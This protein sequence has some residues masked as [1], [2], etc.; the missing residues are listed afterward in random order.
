MMFPLGRSVGLVA[1]FAGFALSQPYRGCSPPRGP[2]PV[3]TTKCQGKTYTYNELA[4]FGSIPSD[5][6]DKFGD[7]VSVGSSAA[8]TDW[9]KKTDPKTKLTSYT[10]TLYGLPDRGWNTEGTQNTIPRVHLFDITFTPG[11]SSSTGA[12]ASPNLAFSYR[13][14][15]LLSAPNGEPMTG[16]DPD[17][18]TTSE[19]YPGFP[20]MPLATYPGDGFGGSGPGGARIALDAE[21]LLLNADGSFWISDEYGPYLYLFSSSGEM[22]QAVAPPD[23]L[24]PVRAW[25]NETGAT[26]NPSFSSNNPPIFNAKKIPA[27][28]D[29]LAGRTNNQGYEGLSAS[30][31]NAETG[32]REIWVLL[33]SASRLEGG[34]D[35]TTR[36]HVRLLKYAVGKEGK[37]KGKGKGKG[38]Y[39]RNKKG[40]QPLEVELEGEYV[41]PL[42]VFT[43]GKGKTKVA[44]Q[45]E[46]KYIG[47]GQLLVLPRDSSVGA[48]TDS[49]TSIYR[50]VDVIDVNGAT[51]VKEKYDAFNASVA[52]IY[53]VLNP[54]VK[55]ATLCPWLDFNVNEQLSKFGMR[56]GPPALPTKSLLNEKWESLALVPVEEG[57]KDEYFL[58][59]LSDNDF[60]TQNGYM[61][62]G[63]N[64]YKDGSGCNLDHQAL[65]FKVTLPKGSKPLIG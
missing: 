13:D 43:D 47:D 40:E 63:K 8:I 46:I 45:S 28:G 44:A 53:G 52:G 14:T 64:S 59:S 19:L 48:C 12:A 37:G 42:P 61:N 2:P 34:Q 32:E 22:L 55:P 36:R 58:F 6:R 35:A 33:Q 9:K 20:K 23:A 51:D 24:L 50:H 1:F 30:P 41:V 25:A 38:N 65:V 60:I 5:A 7:T 16:L 4:G 39:K 18:Y 26:P 3:S 29:P 11:S 49:P 21:G 17:T 15:I 31:E 27:P 54:D 62:G 57:N 10:G 56:N